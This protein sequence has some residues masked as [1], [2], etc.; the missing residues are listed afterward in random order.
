MVSKHHAFWTRGGR[1]L[2]KKY[3]STEKINAGLTH[4][5]HRIA[6]DQITAWIINRT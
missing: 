1:G 5:V 6:F 2:K 4:E 3:G